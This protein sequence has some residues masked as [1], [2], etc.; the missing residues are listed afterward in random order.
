KRRGSLRGHQLSLAMPGKNW[1]AVVEALEKYKVVTTE[2]ALAP[3]RVR[4]RIVQTAALAIH[5]N[6]IP[7]AA[8]TL[9]RRSLAADLLEVVATVPDVE[10]AAALKA[11]RANKTHLQKLIDEGWVEP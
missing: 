8:Q 1:R 6:D 11:T 10:T 5:P 4:P 2:S 9:E 3:P 7:A